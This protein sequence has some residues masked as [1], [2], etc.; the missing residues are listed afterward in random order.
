MVRSRVPKGKAFGSAS[1]ADCIAICVPFARTTKRE[2]M[3]LILYLSFF[4]TNI[5]DK[6]YFD[7]VSYSLEG[8]LGCFLY[9]SKGGCAPPFI[10]FDRSALSFANCVPLI[11]LKVS[12]RYST[13][14]FFFSSP[15][16]SRIICPSF[17]I[18]RR[19]P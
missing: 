7:F 10:Y 11:L 15:L 3:S 14:R 16:M 2:C 18:I 5:Y 19:L 6:S 13:V 12:R 8:T 1:R 17:I 4:F 9:K